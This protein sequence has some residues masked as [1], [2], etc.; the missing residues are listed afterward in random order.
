MA[1]TEKGRDHFTN[2]RYGPAQVSFTC[3]AELAAALLAFDAHTDGQYSNYVR[4]ARKELV[5]AL[6][7]ASG[8]ALRQKQYLEVESFGLGAISA[9]K[10]IPPSEGLDP[11]VV[12]KCKGR[13][14]EAQ[15]FARDGR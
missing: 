14:K 1:C 12:E 7:N 13:I 2:R 5:I 10:H 15:K 3:S 11:G 4:G 6:S 9:A 8:M